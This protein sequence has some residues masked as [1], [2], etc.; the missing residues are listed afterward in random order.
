MMKGILLLYNWLTLRV[1]KSA[2]FFKKI[3]S[4]Y[5]LWRQQQSEQRHLYVDLGTND[6]RHF[7]FG[8]VQ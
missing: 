2:F 7:A 5:L 8:S 6:R 4:L 3:I 1:L